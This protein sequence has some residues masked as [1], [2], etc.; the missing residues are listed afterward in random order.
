[1]GYGRFLV[2]LTF[3]ALMVLNFF[4]VTPRICHQI[5]VLTVTVS[6]NVKQL[7]VAYCLC[8]SGCL[9][10]SARKRTGSNHSETGALHRS[11]QDCEAI[12]NS[13]RVDLL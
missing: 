9:V 12:L 11:T 3:S 6:F 2:T 13:E 1:M 8:P 10:C 5:A 4:D 7:T